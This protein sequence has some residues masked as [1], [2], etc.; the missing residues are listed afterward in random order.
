MFLAEVTC[1]RAPQDP[2]AEDAAFVPVLQ[3]VLCAEGRAGE[4]LLYRVRE[5]FHSEVRSGPPSP[6][7]HGR[8]AL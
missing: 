4:V 2:Q 6:I 7:T 5:E 8:E 3:A 1:R